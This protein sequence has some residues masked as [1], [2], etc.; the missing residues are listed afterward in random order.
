[1]SGAEALRLNSAEPQSPQKNFSAPSGG[2]H[3]RMRSSP[4]RMW[5]ASA[6]TR[7]LADAPVPVRRWQ[8]VQ[9]Q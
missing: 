8:R 4:E 1:M 9:W 3:E 2:A 6:L 5:K 7:A